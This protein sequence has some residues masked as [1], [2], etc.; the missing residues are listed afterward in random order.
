MAAT[1]I[2]GLLG[3]L[4]LVADVEVNEVEGVRYVDIL[5]SE[6]GED[7]GI[8]IGRRGHTLDSLQELMRN[9]VQQQSGDR[10]RVLLD[11][12]DYRKRQR[13]RIVRQAMEVGRKVKRTGRAEALEPMGSF[14]RKLVHDA[15]A[16]IGGLES[17]SE[18]EEPQR[19]VV[20]RRHA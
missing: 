3:A 8:L 11:V 12:E 18:G 17:V 5:N 14:E 6:E 15:V 1:F 4:D 10:C 2:E 16:Q 19:R 9:F 20:I 13:S 7:L